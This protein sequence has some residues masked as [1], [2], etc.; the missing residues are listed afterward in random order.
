MELNLSFIKHQVAKTLLQQ[1]VNTLTADLDA[2]G[3]APAGSLVVYFNVITGGELDAV[4]GAMLGGVETP[5][6]GTMP[7]IGEE[8]QAISRLR[9]FQEIQAGDLIV[10]I[11][12]P[13]LV[14]LF[15]GQI[16]SGVV[17]LPSL[18]TQGVRF[19]WGGKLYVQKEVGEDLLAAWN[20]RVQGL[21]LS[22]TMLLRSST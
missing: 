8:A 1:G 22:G 7:A 11:P 9:Q 21:K 12:D 14:T 10:D 6:S 4:T 13:A 20:T 19:G 17:P 15:D 16:L 5:V 2:S 3:Q 18:A